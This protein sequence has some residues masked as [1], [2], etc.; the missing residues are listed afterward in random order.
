MIPTI[1]TTMEKEP[2]PAYAVKIKGHIK[3]E[4]YDLLYIKTCSTDSYTCFNR[5]AVKLDEIG[6][7]RITCHDICDGVETHF[8]NPYSVLHIPS[9]VS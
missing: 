8:Y 5:C 1:R 6:V 9:F 2:I 3:E 4:K 7:L